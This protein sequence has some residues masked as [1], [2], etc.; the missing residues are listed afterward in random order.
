MR[1]EAAERRELSDATV[2]RLPVYLGAARAL[3]RSGVS[4]VSS[5]ALAAAAGVSPTM[6]RKDL[7]HL[8]SFGVRGVG[9]DTAALVE[10]LVAA[11][12]CGETRPVV[13]VGMGRLGQ[14]IASHGGF[15]GDGFEVVGLFDHDP[16][17]VGTSLLGLTV[18]DVG[19]L[20]AAVADH[21]SRVI[22]VVATPASAAQSVAD[23]LVSSGVGAILNFA[24]TSLQVPASTDVR[25]VDLS[26][27]L[28][29]LAYRSRLAAT[30]APGGAFA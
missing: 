12:G 15:D 6:L 7:S 14:A 5:D 18:Q 27:E 4:N 19:R 1:V 8:G 2:L 28:R 16:Q 11:L 9:Y 30:S 26:S 10:E 13:I 3:A 23:Q 29:L 20:P 24:A 17:V 22:G 21:G 25:A